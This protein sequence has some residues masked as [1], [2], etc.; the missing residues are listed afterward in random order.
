MIACVEYNNFLQKIKFDFMLRVD[1]FLFQKGSSH[2]NFFVQLYT[3]HAK[4]IC[5]KSS[6]AKHQ[7]KQIFQFRFEIF[8]KPSRMMFY[9]NSQLLICTNPIINI[10]SI[11]TNPIINI[12]YLKFKNLFVIYLNCQENVF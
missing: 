10:Q 6:A 3:N 2:Y 1:F 4:G 7:P 5:A 9:L 8:I 12:P 11:Y